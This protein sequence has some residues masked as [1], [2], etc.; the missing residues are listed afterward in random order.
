MDTHYKQFWKINGEDSVEG[1]IDR[2][3]EDVIDPERPIVDPHHH[4][5]KGPKNPLVLKNL[6]DTCESMERYV[7]RS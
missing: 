7:K 6:I 5:W 4:L 3:K 2:V 1:W